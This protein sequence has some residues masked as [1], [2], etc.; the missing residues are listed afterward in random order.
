[1]YIRTFSAL[2]LLLVLLVRLV[3]AAIALTAFPHHRMHSHTLRGSLLPCAHGFLGWIHFLRCCG[4]FFAF[5]LVLTYFLIFSSRFTVHFHWFL[6]WFACLHSVLPHGSRSPLPRRSGL[7]TGSCATLSFCS[8]YPTLTV[9]RVW[10]TAGYCTHV[11]HWFT[12][13]CGSGLW[14]TR[15]PRFYHNAHV[16]TGLVY[17]H[18]TPHSH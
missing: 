4:L 1:L 15:L 7:R 13:G 10:F 16:T 18:T 12:P 2:V 3:T 11:A 17:V 8:G 5:I 14:F 9:T 6:V